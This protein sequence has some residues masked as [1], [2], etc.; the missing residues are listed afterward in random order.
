MCMCV[1]A[2]AHTHTHTY[3]QERKEKNYKTTSYLRKGK[4]T[5]AP[6]TSWIL[7]D[8]LYGENLLEVKEVS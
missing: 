7:L 6:I 2:R 5:L 1:R 4:E 8:C 3:T